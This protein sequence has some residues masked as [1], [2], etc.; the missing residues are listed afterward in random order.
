[1]FAGTRARWPLESERGPKLEG[2]GAPQGLQLATRCGVPPAKSAAMSTML[3]LASGSD[4]STSPGRAPPFNRFLRRFAPFSGRLRPRPSRP[5]NFNEDRISRPAC[6]DAS[7]NAT[8]GAS[9]SISIALPSRRA[10][11]SPATISRGQQ[12]LMFFVSA[13][14]RAKSGLCAGGSCPTGRRNPSRTFSPPSTAQ[15]YRCGETDVS[16]CL[17]ALAVHHSRVRL[18]R[19]ASNQW[20]QAT[21]LFSAAN[22]GALSIAGLWDQWKDVQTGEP[23]LS[24]AM[25]VTEANK[26]AGAF[27]TGC[28][29]FSQSTT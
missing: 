28:R 27:M 3:V 6:A 13:T 8:P 20:R 5:G 26:F 11:S 24:F 2:G 7:H 23:L 29:Y 22:D 19:M 9:S 14:A 21:L 15:R 25:I 16:R 17:P 12:R 1:V 4:R 18:L 10:I